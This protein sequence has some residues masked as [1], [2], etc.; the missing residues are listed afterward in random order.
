M[1]QFVPDE[2]VVARILSAIRA[3]QVPGGFLLISHACTGRVGPETV[4]AARAVYAKTSAGSINPR[5][6]EEI[7]SFFEGYELLEPGLVPVEVWRPEWD[8][9]VPDF[10]KP[11]M[12]G[13]VGRAPHPDPGPAAGGRG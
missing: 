4:A 7:L 3:V 10:T 11:L 8:D 9:I 2:K 13:G 12:L 1:L 6:Y 5:P